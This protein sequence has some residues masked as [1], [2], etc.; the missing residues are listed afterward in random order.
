M[1]KQL[2]ILIFIFLIF[3][4]TEA[5]S[6]KK[7]SSLVKLVDTNLYDGLKYEK[8]KFGNK[9]NQ[10]IANVLRMDLSNKNLN[11]EIL[12]A[13]NLFNHLS[14]INEIIKYN[15][16]VDNKY[17]IAAINAN[18][19]KAYSNKPIGTLIKN[20]K[21]IELKS[22]KEWSSIF[23]DENNIPYI[24][25]FK[26]NCIL[27]INNKKYDITEFNSRKDSNHIV[28]YNSFAGKSIPSIN[29]YDIENTYKQ[30]LFEK[31][32]IET[33]EDSTE[34]EIEY[35]NLLETAKN[36][37][38][39]KN[40]ENKINKILL[41]KIND[42]KINSPVKFI[43]EKIDTGIIYFNDDQYLISPG[44]N[45][46][47]F[48]YPKLKDTVSIKLQTNYLKDKIFINALTGTP[49]LVRNGK[50]VNEATKE[51][52]K[53]KRFIYRKL[54]RTVFGVDKN[55]KKVILVTIPNK[56]LNNMS[57]GANLS[58]LAIFM[59]LIGAYNAIN[60]D[61]GGSSMMIINGFNIDNPEIT[62]MTRRISTAIGIRINKGEK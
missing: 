32:L 10:F 50:A 11:L 53:S 30:L 9:Q 43:V 47:L 57:N 33:F 35:E 41:T 27:D 13:N 4:E 5:S 19:W 55:K 51:G 34:S 58:Q 38:L 7:T 8:Y 37:E 61:G 46:F 56:S 25:N 45:N 26:V 22:Y 29:Q 60:L 17:T 20:G 48:E 16:S 3:F 28:I 36:L 42:E 40:I 6:K 15:D 59:K 1:F 24:D 62:N 54:A 31:A 12:K 44:L 18:F 49:R 39:N 14:K 2:L 23:F 52:L 21:V